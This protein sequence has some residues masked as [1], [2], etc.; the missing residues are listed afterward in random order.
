M[1]SAEI[2]LVEAE[3][4]KTWQGPERSPADG[5][6]LFWEF[7]ISPPMPA[8]WPPAG[9][10]RVVRYLYATCRDP[11]VSDGIRVAAPWGRLGFS[12]GEPGSPAFVRLSESI[13]G[14]GIQGVRPIS[15]EEGLVYKTAD[16]A[17]AALETLERMPNEEDSGTRMLR[18]YYRTWC[19]HNGVM[20]NE[21]STTHN[22]F[23][24]WTG[25]R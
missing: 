25:C 22:P 8:R 11:Q 15:K 6:A 12:G 9:D 24:R 16:R 7:R 2:S 3:W 4:R 1:T 17:E 19:S 14:I 18:D 5:P 13:R 20:V 10:R 23:F 21:L